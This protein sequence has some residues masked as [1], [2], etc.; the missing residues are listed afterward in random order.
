M[1]NSATKTRADLKL[2]LAQRAMRVVQDA[3]TGRDIADPSNP[4]DDRLDT[5]LRDGVEQFWHAHP[6][7][8]QTQFVQITLTPAGDGPISIAGDPT[9][10]LLPEVIQSLPRM[11]ALYRGPET[12]TGGTR[13]HVRH[14]DE[15]I[16]RTF[17]DPNITGMPA[18]L[19]V[20]WS[21]LRAPGMS[22]RGGFEMRVWPKPDR[23]Y[24]VGFR[25]K[26]GA[27]P[28]TENSQRGNW[29]AVHDL[30][31]VA[32]SLRELFRNG[33]REPNSAQM[34]SAEAMVA[35]ELAKSIRID[36]DDYRPQTIGA[37]SELRWPGGHSHS[38]YDYPSGE[39]IL[40]STSF[41]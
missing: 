7:S 22:E 32:F 15:V 28:L 12:T 34:G 36:D 38:L 11:N 2:L 6:W 23:A 20:E 9:R 27:F 29:P 3:T 30:T 39:I 16:Q 24:I 1:L 10:Y 26:V 31:V 40:T 5:A 8:F 35:S 14:M 37:P 18:M 4:T 13:V 25:C 21:S 41:D 17:S 33:D 19:A